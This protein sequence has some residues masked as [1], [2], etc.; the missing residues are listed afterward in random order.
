MNT[1]TPLEPPAARPLDRL[2]W[3]APAL[4]TV[5]AVVGGAWSY[6]SA[7]IVHGPAWLALPYAVPLALVAASWWLPSRPG[8]R[9][10]SL[11]LGGAGALIALTYAQLATFVLYTVAFFLWAFQ[12]GG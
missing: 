9:A 5:V 8:T 10:R 1:P 2:W 7:P 11:V 4:F 3:P 6:H 12:G